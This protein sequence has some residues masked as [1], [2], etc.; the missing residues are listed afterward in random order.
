MDV[1]FAMQTPPQ[2]EG[3]AVKLL[4]EAVIEA[5]VPRE[6]RRVRKH[7]RG[8]ATKL[9]SLP[10]I[11]R[12]VFVR[13]LEEPRLHLVQQPFCPL[14]QGLVSF[15]G[16]PARIA[17]EAIAWLRQVEAAGGFKQINTVV[18]IGADVSFRVGPFTD[19]RGEVMEVVGERAR[20]LFRMLGAWRSSWIEVSKLE[21]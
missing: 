21:V 10:M 19:V 11:P 13:F 5:Y 7:R 8:K 3:A 20:V 16:V 17:G 18:P 9:L 4:P 15:A 6:M 12:Y 2:K 14:S 1:W